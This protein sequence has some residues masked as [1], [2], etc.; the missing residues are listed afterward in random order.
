ML[1]WA[2]WPILRTTRMPC[3][4]LP[5]TNAAPLRPNPCRIFLSPC[6]ATSRPTIASADCGLQTRLQSRL[7]LM[8]L[9]RRSRSTSLI[10]KRNEEIHQQ[11]AAEICEAET[12]MTPLRMAAAYTTIGQ[13][14]EPLR[15][16]LSNNGLISRHTNAIIFISAKHVKNEIRRQGVPWPPPSRLDTV[17]PLHPYH[18]TCDV[19]R[20]PSPQ[21]PLCILEHPL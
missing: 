21:H 7:G 1:G 3:Q 2:R 4:V 19:T 13:C 16:A 8:G 18:D 9:I 12:A 10:P 6:N 11:K 15:N 20:A 14:I 17:A 5:H